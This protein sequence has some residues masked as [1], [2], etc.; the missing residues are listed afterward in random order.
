M[1]PTPDRRTL[2]TGL[3]LGAVGVVALAAVPAL[4]APGEPAPDVPATDRGAST[5]E[6]TLIG[7]A[8]PHHLHVMSF[9]IRLDLSRAD[10]AAD[11]KSVV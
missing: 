6:Q 2:I 9:N 5:V 7:R 1:T 4:S 8:G 3:G 10:E 11:R